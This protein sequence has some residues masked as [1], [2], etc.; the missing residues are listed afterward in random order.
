MKYYVTIILRLTVVAGR[1]KFKSTS[2]TNYQGTVIKY[3]HVGAYVIK[4]YYVKIK[5][6]IIIYFFQCHILV[7]KL[8]EF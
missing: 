7:R 4:Y 8:Y 5:Y 6:Y 1:A 2:Y 3:S